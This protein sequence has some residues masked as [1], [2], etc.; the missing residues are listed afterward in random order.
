MQG[1]HHVQLARC[2]TAYVTALEHQAG[3]L[4][5]GG[6]GVAQGDHVFTQLDTG[7]F[8]FSFQGVSQ[9]IVDGEGQVPLARTE[10]RH[11][12]RFVQRQG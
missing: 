10:V 7:H 3:V 2:H 6:R 11:T 1:D 5:P 12:H 9:V 8:A 4:K